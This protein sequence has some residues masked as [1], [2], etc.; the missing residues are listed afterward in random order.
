[1]ILPCKPVRK[2]CARHRHVSLVRVSPPFFHSTDGRLPIAGSALPTAIEVY[3]VPEKWIRQEIQTGR[4]HSLQMT[5]PL[6]MRP[7]ALRQ[8]R[9][10]YRVLAPRFGFLFLLAGNDVYTWS[11]I[12]PD[13]LTLESLLYNATAARVSCT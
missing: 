7:S 6:P 11:G 10:P 12:A 4:I 8:R 13:R 2:C 9:V 1:M 3:C 5:P